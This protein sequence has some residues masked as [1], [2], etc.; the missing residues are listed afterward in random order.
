MF[1]RRFVIVAAVAVVSL[2]ARSAVVEA[3]T[4]AAEAAGDPR[5]YTGAVPASCTHPLF[6]G[7]KYA[8]GDGPGSVAIGDLDG[9]N[10]PDLAVAN[11]FSD[12]VS[13]LLNTCAFCPWDL[14]GDGEVNVPDLLLL[15]ADFGTCDGPPADF[16]DDGCVGV[17]DLLALIANF[18]PCPGSDCP[19]DIDGDGTVDQTD[20]RLVLGNFGPCD[21]CPEDVNGDGMVNG[22][23]V[24]AVATH[25]G[26]CP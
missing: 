19:W 23:D 17:P 6:V 16:D 21:G 10:G 20:L 9:V 18:G 12:D 5:S 1:N 4:E 8:A 14:S 13:V 11:F 24:A 15:L 26:P 3:P 7:L 25:L 2:L 22:Q